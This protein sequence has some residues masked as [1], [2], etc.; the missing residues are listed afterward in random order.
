[1][2]CSP[3]AP[4]SL[5]ILQA[6]ILEWIAMP[7]SRGIFPAQG[8]NPGLPHCRWILYLLSHQ[9]APLP[10]VNFQWWL[11]RL[12]WKGKQT[13]HQKCLDPVSA[14]CDHHTLV[15][16]PTLTSWEHYRSASDIGNNSIFNC[17][18]LS[19]LRFLFFSES[20]FISTVNVRSASIIHEHLLNL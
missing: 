19:F 15:V 16:W 7:S 18:K 5:G 11:I 10:W 3:P 6:R 2:D 12:N 20:N 1:M 8:L 4:L 17:Q 14:I 9:E 13:Y